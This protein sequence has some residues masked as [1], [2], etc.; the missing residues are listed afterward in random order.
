MAWEWATTE[1][2]RTP[3]DRWNTF[4]RG[5]VNTETGQ[6]FWDSLWNG[7]IS[8]VP[9]SATNVNQSAENTAWWNNL[10]RQMGTWQTG[11][12]DYLSRAAGAFGG[13]TDVMGNYQRSTNDIMGRL[14]NY[15]SLF[16]NLANQWGSLGASNMQAIQQLMNR[17]SPYES[18]YNSYA[19]RGQ[20]LSSAY[21]QD[22]GGLASQLAGYQQTFGDLANQMA[23]YTGNF[24]NLAQ[25]IENASQNAITNANNGDPEAFLRAFQSWQPQFQQM[26]QSTTNNMFGEAGTTATQYAQEAARQA[27]EDAAAQFAGGGMLNSGAAVGAMMQAGLAP[28]LEAAQ[29]MALARG[30]MTAD[31]ANNLYGQGMGGLQQSYG[32][33]RQI[34]S[35][36]PN[37]LA[38]LFGLEGN[39]YNNALGALQA[40]AQTQGMGAD[41]LNN[42]MSQRT[43]Q[44][45][46]QLA[47]LSQEQAATAA[48][49]SILND[50]I[51]AQGTMFN[52][53][54]GALQG[55]QGAYGA[56]ADVLTALLSGN[57][58]LFGNLL[59]GLGTQGQGYGSLAAMLNQLYGQGLGLQGDYAMPMFQPD[60]IIQG[61]GLAD[62]LPGILQAILGMGR[63]G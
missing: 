31:I 46:S 1:N 63:T 26:A 27:R 9:S 42:L 51:G 29:N 54:A 55:Q 11:A 21:G 3:T 16:G 45:Q 50:L 35:D 17:L 13:M 38:A 20:G 28:T 56:G 48:A 40:A 49:Q 62:L 41:V 8:R 60:T 37:Q 53:G 52:M 4:W 39:Q 57:N 15:E 44:F 61:T 30:Q 33:E 22:I 23:G 14:G 58:T 18:V 6:S 19:N 5:P 10:A 25:R 24:D 7:G 12:N 34:Q 36:L 32:L 43:A 47:G 2:T 59:T